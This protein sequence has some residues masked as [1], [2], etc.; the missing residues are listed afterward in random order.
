MCV[1]VCV[2]HIQKENIQLV[3]LRRQQLFHEQQHANLANENRFPETNPGTGSA[4]R[5]KMDQD[6]DQA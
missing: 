1:F 3:D 6:R 5:D 2:C 4:R